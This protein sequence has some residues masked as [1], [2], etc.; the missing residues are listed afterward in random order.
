MLQFE[1]RSVQSLAMKV[2]REGGKLSHKPRAA[3]HRIAD[4]RVADRLHVHADL[5]RSSS[6]E[7]TLELR[8]A[9]A[10]TE[11]FVV[12]HGCF[13]ASRHGH[14]GARDRMAR[15]RRLDSARAGRRADH[16]RDINAA[17]G[18]RL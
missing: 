13:A 16:E 9:F 3:I 11:H 2:A 14:A 10:R 1:S 6:L 7:T 15:N 17:N 4:Q 18:V 12:R 8:P 5:M